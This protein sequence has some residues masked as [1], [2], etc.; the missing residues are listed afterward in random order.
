MFKSVIAFFV[1]AIATFA[2]ALRATGGFRSTGRWQSATV[3]K[4]SSQLQAAPSMINFASTKAGKANAGSCVCGETSCSHMSS[5]SACPCGSSN[6]G[7]SSSKSCPCG[8]A[9]CKH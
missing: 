8:K 2:G 9:F 5:S 6:C 3:V 7:H 4:S 1:L